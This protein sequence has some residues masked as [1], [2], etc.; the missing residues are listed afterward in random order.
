[1]KYTDDELIQLISLNPGF[2]LDRM[3][4]QILP[5]SDADKR[6][7]IRYDIIQLLAEYKKEFE[8]DLYAE[9]QNPD[10]IQYVTENEYKEITGEKYLPRYL[11]RSTSGTSK[12]SDGFGKGHNTRGDAMA[13]IPLPPQTFEWGD[14][15]KPHERETVAQFERWSGIRFYSPVK[16]RNFKEIWSAYQYVLPVEDYSLVSRFVD[17]CSRNVIVKWLPRMKQFHELGILEEWLEITEQIKTIEENGNFQDKEAR[18]AF[19]GTFEEFVKRPEE[20]EAPSKEDIFWV[21]NELN[22]N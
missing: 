4:K 2:G 9:I 14:I 18:L 12:L 17:D 5:D 8:D 21:F 7:D 22:G 16:L 10:Y 20:N 3:I 15:S 11:G 13:N 1:M 6:R 19:R